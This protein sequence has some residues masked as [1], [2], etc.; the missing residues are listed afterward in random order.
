M[1]GFPERVY[2]TTVVSALVVH[3]MFMHRNLHSPS[4]STIPVVICLGFLSFIVDMHML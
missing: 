1:L 2:P 4:H 3:L